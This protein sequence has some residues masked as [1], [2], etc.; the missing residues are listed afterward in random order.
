VTNLLN[1]I[2]EINAIALT[3]GVASFF[4]ERKKDTAESVTVG[5]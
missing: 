2:T 4:E 1:F 3:I 5:Y